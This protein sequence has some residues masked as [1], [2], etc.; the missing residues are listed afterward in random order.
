MNE[1]VHRTKKTPQS[2]AM[3]PK[4]RGN[5]PVNV[6]MRAVIDRIVKDSLLGC[7]LLN[8]SSPP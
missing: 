5:P 8:E 2:M 7:V 1:F 4:M 3:A 6:G